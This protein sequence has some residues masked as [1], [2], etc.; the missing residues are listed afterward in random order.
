MVHEATRQDV[1][2]QVGCE[3]AM[4][5]GAADATTSAEARDKMADDEA[6]ATFFHL[7][8]ER[9]ETEGT[10]VAEVTEGAERGHYPLERTPQMCNVLELVRALSLA[11]ESGPL[12]AG[13]EWVLSTALSTSP[14]CRA[15]LERLESV[16]S[17]ERA[18]RGVVAT[19]PDALGGTNAA[20]RLER[21]KKAQQRLMEQMR[22]QS[23]KFSQFL[24]GDAEASG[25]GGGGSGGGGGPGSA[26]GPSVAPAVAA[27]DTE[28]SDASSAGGR[29]PAYGR[30]PAKLPSPSSQLE[31]AEV[32]EVLCGAPWPA[33]PTCIICHTEDANPI[34]YICCTQPSN[35]LTDASCLPPPPVTSA[36]PP[37]EP[38]LPPKAAASVGVA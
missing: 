2:E 14:E 19:P 15:C 30:F 5:Q 10:V 27:A 29:P 26:D 9:V 3:V 25:P 35:V 37:L 16:E 8:C 11:L 12:R 33:L 34:G 38:P 6:S 7:L 1:H 31:Q 20:S 21:K 18:V 17:D 24:E 28:G 32:K 23:A 4:E 22:Q 36:D 13:C